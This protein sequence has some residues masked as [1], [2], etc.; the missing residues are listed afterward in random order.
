MHLSRGYALLADRG[1][2]VSVFTVMFPASG[3]RAACVPSRN[4]PRS[5]RN[6]SSGSLKRLLIAMTTRTVRTA[7]RVLNKVSHSDV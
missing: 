2:G 5:A 1:F 3:Q 6:G 4:R 7:R